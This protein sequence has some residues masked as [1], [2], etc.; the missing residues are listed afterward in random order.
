MSLEPGRGPFGWRVKIEDRDLHVAVRDGATDEVEDP[1]GSELLRG[2]SNPTYG[3]LL[4]RT[5]DQDQGCRVD[6]RV[7]VSGIRAANPANRGLAVR[8]DRL[9]RTRQRT[10]SEPFR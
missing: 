7:S 6:K 2:L 3:I 8:P 10:R 4:A 5:L 9:A 1:G